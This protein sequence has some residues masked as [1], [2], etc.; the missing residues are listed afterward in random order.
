VYTWTKGVGEI[1]TS[2]SPSDRTIKV[3][4]EWGLGHHHASTL[5]AAVIKSRRMLEM[6]GGA[7]AMSAVEV[8]K[9]LEM[10]EGA[11]AMSVVEVAKNL[12]FTTEEEE[13]E[14]EV[15]EE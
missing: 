12:T 2:C 10:V 6:V 14:V 9:M 8:A 13:E 4:E 1:V 5:S 3:E 11:A 7:A 15:E